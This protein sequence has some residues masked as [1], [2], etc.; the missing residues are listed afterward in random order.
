[1]AAGIVAENRA[2]RREDGTWPAMTSTSSAKPIRSISSASSMTR[3]RTAEQIEAAALDEVHDAAGVPTRRPGRRPQ[4]RMRDVSSSRRRPAGPQVAG[5][6]R[7]GG[8]GVGHLHACS[9][10]GVRTTRLDRPVLGVDGGEQ[11]QPE[12]G[13]LPAGLAMPTT[14][15]GRRAGPGSPRP[16]CRW[17]WSRPRSE[18]A[19]RRSAGRP[20]SAKATASGVAS[21][22]ADSVSGS[23]VSDWASVS[24]DESSDWASV[25]ATVSVSASAVSRLGVGLGGRGGAHRG[26]AVLGDSNLDGVVGQQGVGSGG[27]GR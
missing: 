3:K 8:D 25:S 12:R 19:A 16:G 21:S 1:M 10:V 18:T 26:G 24:G 7:E 20:R 11:R 23:R 22:S 17:G 27:Q 15:R 4:A 6:V 2:V 13:R 9:R 14:R 5:A